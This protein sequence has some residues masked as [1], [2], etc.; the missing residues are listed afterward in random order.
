MRWAGHV[1]HIGERRGYTRFWSGNVR[2]RDHLEDPGVDGKIIFRLIF[3][4]WDVGLWTVSIWLRI[5]TGGELFVNAVIYLRFHK[6]RG[7]S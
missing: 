4:K 7:I 1:A 3:R 2:E 5:R 6:M